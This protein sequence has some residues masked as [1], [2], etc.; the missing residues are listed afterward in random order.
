VRYVILEQTMSK[1]SYVQCALA[2]I[3]AAVSSSLVLATEEAARLEVYGAEGSPQH[4]AISISPNVELPSPTGHDVVILFD[5]SASQTGYFREK[6]LETLGHFV[7]SLKPSSRVQLM[8]VDLDAHPLTSQF[9]APDSPEF[10]QAIDA[11]KRRAPLGA[12]NLVAALDGAINAYDSKSSNERSVVYLGDGQS[13]ANFLNAESM[14]ELAKRLV[15]HR[16]AVTSYAVGPRTDAPVLAAIANQS[17]G[18]LVVDGQTA[19]VKQVASS[20]TTI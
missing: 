1:R 15:D 2:M 16:V 19:T 5:T 14:R 3:V 7:D 10:A 13:G 8:A 6:A 20:A 11:L 18:P 17:G 4:F 9:V 12:T